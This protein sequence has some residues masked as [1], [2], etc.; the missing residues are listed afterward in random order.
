MNLKEIIDNIVKNPD[1]VVKGKWRG[2][3]E[4]LPN[5]NRADGPVDFIIKGNDVVVAKKGEFI[6]VLK[7][8]VNN[9]RVK[10][11]RGK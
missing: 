10:E 9:A 6:T 5:G 2:Q 3:G 11:A 4:V 1:E 8:G 7:D